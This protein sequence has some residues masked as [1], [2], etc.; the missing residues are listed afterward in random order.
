MR[1][2]ALATMLFAAFC[3]TSADGASKHGSVT[4]C[5]TIGPYVVAADA[6]L[7]PAARSA[8]NAGMNDTQVLAGT[9]ARHGSAYD[10]VE[11]DAKTI[12]FFFAAGMN[13]VTNGQ[14]ALDRVY[15]MPNESTFAGSS[16]A[17]YDGA[18]NSVEEFGQLAL[19]YERSVNS[20]N[21]SA[22][23]AALSRAF[24]AMSS[25]Y[26]SSYTNLNATCFG[27]TCY[28]SGTTT[29]TN[30]GGAAQ[31]A[32]AA[33]SVGSAQRAFTVAEQTPIMIDLTL[34][35]DDY[36]Y[37]YRRLRAVW[38]SACPSL[39]FPD[40]W[41][42]AA[43]ET[44]AA[45]PTPMV[46]T[47]A[48]GPTPT[49]T[50]APKPL[51]APEPASVTFTSSDN[52][53]IRI[54]RAYGE[55]ASYYQ[56]LNPSYGWTIISRYSNDYANR[57]TEAFDPALRGAPEGLYP[58]REVCYCKSPAPGQYLGIFYE[59]HLDTHRTYLIVGNKTLEQRYGLQHNPP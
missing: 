24:A 42:R 21:R 49:R 58:I 51:L 33:A 23:A 28:G 2:L 18:L 26:S 50:S 29:T 40:H 59:V 15:L 44:V 37:A 36:Q 20:R 8:V 1:V 30:Y 48:L 56:R 9:R 41:A 45:R 34:K 57:S 53:A 17:A 3:V 4:L 39:S 32:A 35:M 54:A 55:N 22:F 16:L 5:K 11:A 38:T 27:N 14:I 10:A 31:N 52:E 7:A 19:L 25:S 13:E 12:A 46:P 47:P 43:I 6:A